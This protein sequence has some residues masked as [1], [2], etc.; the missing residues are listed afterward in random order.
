MRHGNWATGRVVAEKAAVV[1]SF[2]HEFRGSGIGS[3]R[4][5]NNTERMEKNG[6][7]RKFR[8]PESL[9]RMSLF[10]NRDAKK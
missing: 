10:S 3:S 2:R 1:N 6:M 5:S 8:K 4:G 7:I 9:D